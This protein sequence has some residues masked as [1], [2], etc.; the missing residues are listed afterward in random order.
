[1]YIIYSFYTYM[2]A[3][4]IFL[5]YNS[6]NNNDKFLISFIVATF[7]SKTKPCHQYANRFHSCSFYLQETK[8]RRNDFTTNRF[9]RFKEHAACWN[10]TKR[11]VLGETLLHLCFHNN[12]PVHNEIAKILLQL[13]PKLAVDIVEKEERYGGLF[14]ADLLLVKQK[15]CIT[16]S[17]YQYNLYNYVILST[18]PV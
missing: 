13:Y 10:L 16:K 11:G 17:F 9:T 7:I 3:P 14:S 1:M 2:H 12:T 6:F 18:Q 5:S 8:T 15:F 4:S